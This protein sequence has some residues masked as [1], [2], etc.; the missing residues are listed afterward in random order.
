MRTSMGLAGQIF[1]QW[2]D[3][4]VGE[5]ADSSLCLEAVCLCVLCAFVLVERAEI[6]AV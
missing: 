1:R 6:W 5:T 4:R 2:V 3:S